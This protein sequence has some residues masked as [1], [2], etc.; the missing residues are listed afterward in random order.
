MTFMYVFFEKTWICYDIHFMK[1]VLHSKLLYL[2]LKGRGVRHFILQ[3]LY[4]YSISMPIITSTH[5]IQL[6]T[7][8]I[9]NDVSRYISLKVYCWCAIS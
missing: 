3:N 6:I 1:S 2:V 8:M 5:K 7:Q 9:L 4:T